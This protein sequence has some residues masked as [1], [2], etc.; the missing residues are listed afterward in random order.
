[1]HQ[2]VEVGCLSMCAVNACV[3]GRLSL[4]ACGRSSMCVFTNIH[5]SCVFVCVCVRARS[6]SQADR[7]TLSLV[8]ICVCICICVRVRTQR[9]LKAVQDITR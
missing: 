2:H 9:H 3:C 5:T 6:L 8:G 4:S 7:L 1:M